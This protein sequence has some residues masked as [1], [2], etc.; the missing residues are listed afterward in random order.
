[1]GIGLWRARIWVQILPQLLSSYL[2]SSKATLE[3]G[4]LYASLP[5]LRG[6]WCGLRHRTCTMQ[7]CYAISESPVHLLV[8]KVALPEGWASTSSTPDHPMGV[9]PLSPV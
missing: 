5:G 8:M 3:I 7:L 4:M 2:A 9:E 1:M 6:A